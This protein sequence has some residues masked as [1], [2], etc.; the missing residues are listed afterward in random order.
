MTVRSESAVKRGQVWADN[1]RRSRGRTVRILR[2]DDTHAVVTVLA[3]RRDAPE[4]ERLR[5]VGA[6]RRIRL[7]RFRPNSTGYR[8]MED[9][10]GERD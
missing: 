10:E 1:D 9:V 6:E 5:A 3:A 2:V 4:A 7:N 8:L